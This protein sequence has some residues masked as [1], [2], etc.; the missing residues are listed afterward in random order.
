MPFH[1]EYVRSL[2]GR[3]FS[4]KSTMHDSHPMM[5]KRA[6]G[7]VKR[8]PNMKYGSRTNN[9]AV[10]QEKRHM[11]DCFFK[12]IDFLVPPSI[13]KDVK[14]DSQIEKVKRKHDFPGSCGASW[15]CCRCRC[16]RDGAKPGN[17]DGMASFLRRL[18]L[19]GPVG[20]RGSVSSLSWTKSS[21]LKCSEQ[22]AEYFPGF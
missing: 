14:L 22:I 11:G 21:S 9:T 2:G 13:V 10:R 3:K 5:R 8:Q 15:L 20:L 17:F 4:R 1:C 16:R 6:A 7:Q 18:T 19:R 12:S